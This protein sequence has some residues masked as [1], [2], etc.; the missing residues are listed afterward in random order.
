MTITTSVLVPMGKE[1]PPSQYKEQFFQHKT[2]H[3]PDSKLTFPLQTLGLRSHISNWIQL[4]GKSLITEIIKQG[5]SPTWSSIPPRIIQHISH[6]QYDQSIINTKLETMKHL[7]TTIN[8]LT[9]LGFAINWE[10]SKL[11]PS[12]S[13]EFLGFTICSSKMTI[14]LPHHKVKEVIRECKLTLVKPTIHIRKL[15]SLIGKLITTTNAIFPARLMTRDLLRDK[16]TTLRRL[17]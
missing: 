10:K 12:K 4:F 3:K 13:I 14:S 9:S 7:D 15:A 17:G 2:E 16:N 5:Y 11:I 6:H 8:L 1:E